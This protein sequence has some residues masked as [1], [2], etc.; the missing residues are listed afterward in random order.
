[1]RSSRLSTVW[2]DEGG[3]FVA[4]SGQIMLR[5]VSVQIVRFESFRSHNHV[6]VINL[7]MTE[8]KMRFKLSC[9]LKESK[10]KFIV[11]SSP[12]RGVWWERLIRKVKEPLRNGP[13]KSFAVQCRVHNSPYQ[14]RSCINTRPLTTVSGDIQDSTSITPPQPAL[15]IQS[16]TFLTLE[17]SRLMKTQQGN[18]TCTNRRS[19]ITSGSDVEGSIYISYSWDRNG[20]NSN[21]P[22]V[23]EI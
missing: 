14:N 23:L 18:V 19:L 7:G 2:S 3:D 17:K 13:R 5:P 15:R 12:W 9:R 16:W 21:Q 6:T 22:L 10:C 11:E 20:T 8:I 4:P 1:M